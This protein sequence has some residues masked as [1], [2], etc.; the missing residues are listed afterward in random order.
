MP[1]RLSCAVRHAGL[2]AGPV[3]A[4]GLIITT[5]LASAEPIKAPLAIAPQ[6]PPPITRTEPATVVVELEGT[7]FTGMLADNTKYKFWGFNDSVPG[8]MIRVRVGDTVEAV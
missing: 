8:P 4:L 3:V 7:E 1:S 2:I 5:N 6:V